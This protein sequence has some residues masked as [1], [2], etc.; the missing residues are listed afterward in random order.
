MID[1]VNRKQNLK[2]FSNLVA[3]PWN[4]G[5]EHLWNVAKRKFEVALT[6]EKVKDKIDFNTMAIVEEILDST[7]D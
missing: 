3:E 2:V 6:E 4:M 1:Y 7:P 5:I